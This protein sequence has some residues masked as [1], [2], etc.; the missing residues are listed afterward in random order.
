MVGSRQILHWRILSGICKVD[1]LFQSV[2]SLVWMGLG[3]MGCGSR[4]LHDRKHSQGWYQ[5]SDAV[6]FPIFK[7][8]TRRYLQGLHPVVRRSREGVLFLLSSRSVLPVLSL[9]PQNPL[10]GHCDPLDDTP[11]RKGHRRHRNRCQMRAS[12]V[13]FAILAFD[14]FLAFNALFALFAL[15]VFLTFDTDTFGTNLAFRTDAV[16]T[17]SIAIA[18]RRPQSRERPSK[19]DNPKKPEKPDKPDKPDNPASRRCP[20][21]RRPRTRDCGSPSCRCPSRWLEGILR[22]S[23]PATRIK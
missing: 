11:D 6:Q 2:S 1:F 12:F 18:S 22:R 3:R 7:C 8:D 17:Y 16:F 23:S 10:Q 15:F 4:L 20:R 5:S 14:A 21:I 19:P 13:R 9:F